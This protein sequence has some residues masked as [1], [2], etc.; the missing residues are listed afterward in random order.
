VVAHRLPTGGAHCI[1]ALT[2]AAGNGANSLARG[3]DDHRQDQQRQRQ[4][5]RQD[6]L[7]EIERVHEQP[8]RQQAVNDRRHAGQVGDVDLDDL[9][10]PVLPGVLLQIHARGDAERNR[11]QGGHQ[12]DQGGTDQG[13]EDACLLG[14]PRREIA[15]EAPVQTPG[16][17]VDQARQQQRQGQHTDHQAQQADD[18]EHLVPVL[19]ARHQAAHGLSV[20]SH[21]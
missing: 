13:T 3:D 14:P 2:D 1:G 18:D 16:A 15:E 21:Q 8:Q 4:A 6:A 9:G 7:T 5:R 17:V 10:Q 20:V 12:H 11:R 19:A